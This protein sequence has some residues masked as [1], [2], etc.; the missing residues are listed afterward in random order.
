MRHTGRY[1]IAL[2][3]QNYCVSALSNTHYHLQSPIRDRL[4]VAESPVTSADNAAPDLRISF[5]NP[6]LS[7]YR[8]SVC[9]AQILP[10][11]PR[12]IFSPDDDGH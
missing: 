12:N 5:C 4:L 10:S 3:S 6:Y 9:V 2:R 11:P 8:K 1:R 7:D